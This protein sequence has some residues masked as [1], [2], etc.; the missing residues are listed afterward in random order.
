[1]L[2]RTR[3]LIA[4]AAAATIAATASAAAPAWATTA[5]GHAAPGTTVTSTAVQ[6]YWEQTNHNI[7]LS[8][9]G[10]VSTPIMTLKLAAGKWVLHADQ[11]MVNFGPSDYAGCEIGDTANSD[12]NAHNNIVGDP[13]ATGAQ[14]PASFVDT[15]SE[16]AA[17][18]L[19]APTTVT[20][21]C[22]HNNTNGATPYINSNA[23]LWA[24][25][26]SNLVITQLP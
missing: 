3:I 20:I 26:S 24:H 17:V 15:L 6:D 1:M 18:S 4:C 22:G 25:R 2:T 9:T 12:L 8:T 23:D 5:T 10:G 21:T 14:G 19:S 16:T 11:T 7:N 13:N